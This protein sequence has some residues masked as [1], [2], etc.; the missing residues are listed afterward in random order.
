MLFLNPHH[1]TANALAFV[2]ARTGVL[3][4]ADRLKHAYVSALNEAQEIEL[5][6]DST[7]RVSFEDN[8]IGRRAAQQ[9]LFV[10]EGNEL[11]P[12]LTQE[13]KLLAKRNIEHAVMLI[14]HLDPGIALVMNL[15]VSDVV[16]VRVSGS[17]GGT[18][19][20]LLGAI[21]LSPHPRWTTIDYAECLVHEMVHLNVFLGDSV[22]RIYV[23]A[24][25]VR[26]DDAL[27]ISAVRQE[28]RPL[29]KSLHSACVATTLAYFYQL[30]GDT[31]TADG[32]IP[33]LRR[34]VAEL[35]DVEGRHLTDYG[36]ALVAEL[37]G[38]LDGPDYDRVAERIWDAT[39]L[40]RWMPTA[41]AVSRK[42]SGVRTYSDPK[43]TT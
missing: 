5:S 31:R 25:R 3:P 37:D 11:A 30:L 16:C 26:D 33:P 34:C 20:N 1:A 17:G 8:P 29:D 14:E 22:H 15:V 18:A 38:F 27:V 24:R 23:D 6:T 4:P 32:F 9:A 12:T 42:H 28:K 39:L 40:D 19:S 35:H 7:I 41:W 2:F 43:V 10:G 13:E 21:W 36:Q